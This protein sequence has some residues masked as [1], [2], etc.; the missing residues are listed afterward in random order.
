MTSTALSCAARGTPSAITTAMHIKR[1]ITNSFEGRSAVGRSAGRQ[2]GRLGLD[3]SAHRVPIYPDNPLLPTCDLLLPYLPTCRPALPTALPAYLPTCLPA[4]H[5]PTCRPTYLP[6]LLT[7]RPA[8]PLTCRPA[9][10][11][12]SMNT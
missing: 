6:D 7:C 2:V 8:D 12:C 5:R 4:R 10:P 3:P 9:R 1:F 11:G